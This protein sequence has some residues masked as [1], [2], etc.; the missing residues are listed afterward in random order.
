MSGNKLK[1]IIACAT[2]IAVGAVS[3]GAAAVNGGGGDSSPETA[4]DE[5]VTVEAKRPAIEDIVVESEFIGTVDPNRQVTVFPKAA[6]EILSMNYEQGDYVEEGAVL[7]VIDSTALALTISQT[8]AAVSTAQQRANYALAMAQND[9]DVFEF[10]QENDFNASLIQTGTAVEQ[11]EIGVKN[12]ESGLEAAHEQVRSARLNYDAASRQLRDYRRDGDYPLSMVGLEGMGDDDRVERQLRDA[13]RQADVALDL[14][15]IG[16]E[17]AERAVEAAKVNL[18]AAKDAERVAKVGVSEQRNKQNQAIE[19]ARINSNLSDQYINITRM[20]NDLK[21]YTVTAN[22]SGV[23]ESRNQDPRDMA[24]PQVP[25]FTI[26]NKDSMIVEFN[27]SEAALLNMNIG[28]SVKIEK[29]NTVYTGRI[30]ET[31]ISVDARSGLFTVKARLDSPPESLLG[32]S[33]VKVYAET[34]KAA[35]SIVI[36][37]DSV[38]YEGGAPYVFVAENGLAK[39]V[40]IET[41]IANNRDIQVLS[42]ITANDLV[43]V[44]WNSNLRDGTGLIITK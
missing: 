1:A 31:A 28:D 3:I 15:Q 14:A 39:K 23:I 8:R 9:L 6:G 5:R 38:Y 32:G 20:E 40:S 7:A 29:N 36:P 30:T 18:E 13:V 22:I 2:V 34:Q 12:A 25:M 33:A 26:A 37:I 43:I 4:A 35:R 41:G 21:N 44:T 17:N 27:V 42:G 16:V 11:A 10:K 19:M 24:A